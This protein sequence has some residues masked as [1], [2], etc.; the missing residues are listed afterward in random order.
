MQDS[1]RGFA[2][3]CAVPA[4]LLWAHLEA[5]AVAVRAQVRGELHVVVVRRV[6]YVHARA[7]SSRQL[8]LQHTRLVPDVSVPSP[9]APPIARAVWR[10]ERMVDV[11]VPAGCAAVRPLDRVPLHLR[12]RDK[13]LAA[14][15][16]P[17][18]DKGVA[19]KARG[20]AAAQVGESLVE[21]ELLVEDRLLPPAKRPVVHALNERVR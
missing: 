19:R 13:M 5:L 6:G 21:V 2:L 9:V 8:V 10:R 16:R 18:P 11:V 7:V 17:G 15:G 20:A 14:H 3:D 12:R 1:P 4:P